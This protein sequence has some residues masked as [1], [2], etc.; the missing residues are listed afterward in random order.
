MLKDILIPKLIQYIQS[1]AQWHA[2]GEPS[3]IN[4]GPGLAMTEL[5]DEILKALGLPCVALKYTS[6]M[7]Q[8]GFH[9]EDAEERAVLLYERLTREAEKFLLSPAKSATQ[10]LMEY[11]AQWTAAQDALPFLAFDYTRYTGFLYQDIYLNGRCTEAELLQYLQWVKEYSATDGPVIPYESKMLS[12]ASAY[13][14][15]ESLSLPFLSEYLRYLIYLSTSHPWDI[16]YNEQPSPN[17][18]TMEDILSLSLFY[19]CRYI[20]YDEDAVN[21]DLM[22]PGKESYKTLSVWCE[23]KDLN[24]LLRFARYPSMVAHLQVTDYDLDLMESSYMYD[25]YEVESRNHAI[26]RCRIVLERIRVKNRKA[27][28]SIQYTLRAIKPLDERIYVIQ[29][30]DDDLPF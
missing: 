21:L 17:K 7:Q 18:K 15:F 22:I 24:Y 1:S 20:I 30:E 6:I 28:D 25:A 29:D 13:Q 9:D 11:K 16:D 14:H 19:L 12:T 26:T 10:S 5:E 23:I 4:D 2:L 27:P 8:Q 3:P